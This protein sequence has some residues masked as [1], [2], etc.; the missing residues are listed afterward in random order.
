MNLFNK[1]E[2]N[3]SKELREE[4][5]RILRSH[6][7]VPSD[8]HAKVAMRADVDAVKN[9]RQAASGGKCCLLMFY[10]PPLIFISLCTGLI[11]AIRKTEKILNDWLQD[12]EEDVYVY[13]DT[14]FAILNGGKVKEWSPMNDSDLILYPLRDT[15]HYKSGTHTIRQ[16][17][18][19]LKKKVFGENNRSAGWGETPISADVRLGKTKQVGKK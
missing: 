8:F 9:A 1:A 13:G 19:I 14:G 3:K 4:A 10:F 15:F 11:C 12:A 16:P 7:G 6:K 18:L 2:D 5:T 17:V